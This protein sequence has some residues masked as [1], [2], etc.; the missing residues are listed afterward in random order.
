M[1]VNA[2]F[3]C[4]SMGCSRSWIDVRLPWSQT[5]AS[6]PYTFSF[7]LRFQQHPDACARH[8]LW[9]DMIPRPALWPALWH[10]KGFRSEQL[11]FA[12]WNH[13]TQSRSKTSVWLLHWKSSNHFRSSNV[14]V[15][16]T[17]HF[18]FDMQR[19]FHVRK[20]VVSVRILC[21]CPKNGMQVNQNQ[22][23]QRPT[24]LF[25]AW[26]QPLSCETCGAANRILRH[27]TRSSREAP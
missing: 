3:R 18:E 6:R 27:P 4:S 17:L 1:Y 25:W 7:G 8:R 22:W 11:G 10:G 14:E 9:H 23:F 26:G 5:G 2:L 13:A 19:A 20:R 12:T 15:S 24:T 16:A 21:F